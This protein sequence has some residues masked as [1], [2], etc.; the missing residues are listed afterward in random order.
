MY[1]QAFLTTFWRMELRPKV[2]VAMSFSEEYQARF[3][4]VIEPSIRSIKQDGSS[5]EPLRVDLSISGDSVLTEILDGIAHSRLVLADVSSVGKDSKS[6]LTYR[7]GNVMYEVGVALACRHPSE[8]L[9]VRDDHDN[10]LFDVSVIPHMTIDF[11]EVESARRSLETAL[12]ERLREQRL[13]HDARVEMA[14]AQLSSEEM[15][16]LKFAVGLPPGTPWGRQHRQ[17]AGLHELA[18]S[19]LLDK[20]VVKMVGRFPNGIPAYAL[21]Q[22]GVAV[23][24][25]AVQSGSVVKDEIAEP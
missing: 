14:T 5:L 4:N 18:I 7:N 15:N 2:F 1:P 6:G 21:T 23:A 13:V 19:R 20:Q 12:R 9:L 17:F 24:Q 10:F 16:E 3:E 25:Q 8:V 11:T 22:L